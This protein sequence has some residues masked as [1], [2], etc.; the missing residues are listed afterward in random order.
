[1]SSSNMKPTKS[2]FSVNSTINNT[3]NAT[4]NNYEDSLEFDFALCH[5]HYSCCGYI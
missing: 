2:N 4:N 1:M 5:W 3:Q